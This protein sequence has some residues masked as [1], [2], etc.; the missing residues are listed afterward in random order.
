VRGRLKAD[1]G[2]ETPEWRWDWRSVHERLALRA[3]WGPSNAMSTTAK[4]EDGGKYGAAIQGCVR[5]AK[6]LF[7]DMRDL[8]E[9][10][11]FE[12][13]FQFAIL[14]QE[15]CAK[16]F[17][18]ALINEGILPWTP[19]VER[20]M[21]DHHCKHLVGIVMWWLNPSHEANCE[22]SRLMFIDWKP[23]ELP[24]EVADAINL[25][26]FEKIGRWISQSWDWSE[27]P[28]W[29][30]QARKVAG[31]KIERTKQR[32][33][34]T[35]VGEDGSYQVPRVTAEDAEAEYRRAEQMLEIADGR[36][37]MSF[38][39]HLAVK[40]AMRVIFADLHPNAGSA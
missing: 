26:R 8:F 4:P 25:L 28:E 13:S 32:A 24:P 12:A 10:G 36:L 21:K 7:L 22:R 40:E 11:R 33:V 15:E 27:P 31:G 18:L 9:L 38:Q 5:N 37:V 23:A 16:A 39:E 2:R 6:R 29:N 34:Y 1:Y 20:A 30:P 3:R 17:L 14:T 19:Q 35:H